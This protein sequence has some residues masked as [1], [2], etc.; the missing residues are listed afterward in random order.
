MKVTQKSMMAL[1]VALVSLCQAQTEKEPSK[2]KCV[3]LDSSNVCGQ[4]YTGLPVLQP[5]FASVSDFNEKLG[6]AFLNED[7]IATE[8]D[9]FFGCARNDVAPFISS[10]RFQL[11]FWCS[12]AVS[13]AVKYGCTTNGSPFRLCSDECESSV[14]SIQAIFDQKEVC[15]GNA[16]QV[17]NRKG[18]VNVMSAICGASK[19]NSGCS[20]G[21]APENKY[22]GKY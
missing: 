3:T 20:H 7:S 6:K 17:E 5:A 21:T 12:N 11:S 1:F 14:K 10:I 16:T 22:C 19:T 9:Q 13:D 2:P 8:F 18:L 4:V 15:K